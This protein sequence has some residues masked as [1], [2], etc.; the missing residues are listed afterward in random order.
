MDPHPLVPFHKLPK[1]FVLAWVPCPFYVQ[2]K[3]YYGWYLCMF[4]VKEEAIPQLLLEGGVLEDRSTDD[5][6]KHLSNTTSSALGFED[7][8]IW[9]F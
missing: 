4:W 5:H 9:T 1:E 3:G 7:Q 2:G 6:S 8:D